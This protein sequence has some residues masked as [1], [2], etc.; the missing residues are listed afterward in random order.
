MIENLHVRSFSQMSDESCVIS[1]F[2]EEKF[3]SSDQRVLDIDDYAD[4]AVVG[5]GYRVS[6]VRRVFAADGSCYSV[7]HAP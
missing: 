2:L 3:L 4:I 6:V 5:I 1:Q 7:D